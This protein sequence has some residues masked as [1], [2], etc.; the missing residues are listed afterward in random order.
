M[1]PNLTATVRNVSVT[2]HM[3]AR[4]VTFHRTSDTHLGLT[5]VRQAGTRFTYPG[6]M[7][8]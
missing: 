2:Y 7:E 3:G 5:R 4:S 1:G 8:G 6:G